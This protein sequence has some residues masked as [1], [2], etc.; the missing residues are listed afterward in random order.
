MQSYLQSL[1][2]PALQFLSTARDNLAGIALGARRG[3]DLGAYLG[4]LA[5]L[6]PGFQAMLSTLVVGAVVLVT[7]AMARGAYSLYLKFK[8]GVKWW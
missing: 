1:L 4:P 6:G 8:A 3:I 7:L 2:N 5:T